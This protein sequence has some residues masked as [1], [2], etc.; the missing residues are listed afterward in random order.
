MAIPNMQGLNLS[1]LA[2]SLISQLRAAHSAV[3]TAQTQVASNNYSTV[4]NLPSVNKALQ[5]IVSEVQS[6]SN[7]TE[8]LELVNARLPTNVT[9]GEAQ[10]FAS[11]LDSLA[12]DIETNANL[13][14]LSINATTKRTEYTTPLASGVQTTLISKIGAVL[15]EVS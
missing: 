9:M 7:T 6:S 1:D 15:A 5:D 8:I 2:G 3:M 11:A 14:L 4:V 10:S 13:F 12:S